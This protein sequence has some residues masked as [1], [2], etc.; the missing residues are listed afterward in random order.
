MNLNKWLINELY[1]VL[2]MM[3]KY[4][5]LSMITWP[6]SH[7][8]LYDGWVLRFANGYTRRSNS[9]I[10]IYESTISIDEKIDY[11]E[12]EYSLHSLPTLFKIT[13]NS[14]PNGIDNRLQERGYIK[15]NEAALRVLDLNLYRMQE[16]KNV[17]VE[18]QFSDT[19][20][21][22]FFSFSKITDEEVK[23]TAREILRNILGKVI[24]VTKE[25]DG[26]RVG[27]GYGAV[28]REHIGIFD[29]IVDE[30]YRGQGYAKDLMN[31]ILVSACEIGVK[32]AF[33]QVA[34][35]NIPAEKLYNKIGFKE[36]YRYWYR[37][38]EK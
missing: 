20:L 36:I 7:T 3:R 26:R 29:I 21:N 19:W 23:I 4:E 30:N 34:V 38:F 37:K 1:G 18:T 12:N 24:C 9:V 2:T 13:S 8:K 33:L 14:S 6:S 5:E 32:N 25:V 17:M 28:E 22:S 16:Y 10:P 11:C 31:S 35:G 15:E 27:C